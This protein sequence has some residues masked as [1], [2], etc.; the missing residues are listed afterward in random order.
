MAMPSEP[1]ESRML[2]QNRPARLRLVARAGGHRCSEGLHQRAPIGLLVVAHAH[3]VDLAFQAEERAR[4]GQRRA[5]LPRARLRRQ[6]LG[7]FLLVVVG[8]RHRGVRLVRAGR[9]HAFVLV[10]NLRRRIQ[11]LLQP[12][13]AK[14]RRRPPLRVH[15]PHRRRE[16]RSPAPCSLPAGSGSWE[17]AAPGRP[18]Q[19]ASAFPDAAAAPCG[20]GRSATNV[21]PG[22]GNAVLRQVV[23]DCFHAQHFISGDTTSFR[24]RLCPKSALVKTIKANRKKFQ[25]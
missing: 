23:L 10:V 6:A 20:F 19:S 9:A 3:H 21:V 4:H 15:L 5:P 18:A 25:L 12:A 24:P 14:Q 22:A 11:R 13:R 8:L 16:S 7:A 2:G 1:F 17:T